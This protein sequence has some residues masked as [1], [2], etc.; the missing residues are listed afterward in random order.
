MKQNEVFGKRETS[1]PVNTLTCQD[2][3]HTNALYILKM[4]EITQV[5]K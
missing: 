2:S 3:Q 1:R 5:Y 4:K